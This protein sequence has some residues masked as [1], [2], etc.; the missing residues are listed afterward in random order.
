MIKQYFYEIETV[1]QI[2]L[3]LLKSSYYSQKFLII[4]FIVL[5]CEYYFARSKRHRTLIIILVLLIKNARNSKVKDVS[6]HSISFQKIIMNKKTNRHKN[7]LKLTKCLLDFIRL[8]KRILFILVV[9][10]QARQRHSYFRI[11][12]YKALIKVNEFQNICTS[13]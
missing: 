7:I 2:M 5:L 12:I 4:D 3:S 1:F 9:F 10:E 8:F 13:R 11:T 6:F